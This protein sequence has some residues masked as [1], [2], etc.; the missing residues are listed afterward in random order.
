MSF[1]LSRFQRQL[2]HDLKAG[3]SGASRQ[4]LLT[5]ND[6]FVRPF[7]D[8]LN[9]RA[10][11]DPSL[12]AYSLKAMFNDQARRVGSFIS[13]QF[14][15]LPQSELAPLIDKNGYSYFLES[16]K[17]RNESFCIGFIQKLSKKIWEPGHGSY[18][19]PVIVMSNR[20]LNVIKN[21]QP[22]KLLSTL[23]KLFSY[24]SHDYLHQLTPEQGSANFVQMRTVGNSKI[25]EWGST[26]F[27]PGE[28][29][30]LS[31]ES[32]LIMSHASSFHDVCMID[33]EFK[34]EY[35]GHIDT[36]FSELKRITDE[37]AG[38]SPI[39]E[40]KQFV[41]QITNYLGIACIAS[42]ARLHKM[43]RAI[44]TDRVSALKAIDPND[45]DQESIAARKEEI[46]M[47]NPEVSELMN[48]LFCHSTEE[49]VQRLSEVEKAMVVA[50]HQETHA[51][52]RHSGPN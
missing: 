34:N 6:R 11:G 45:S 23:E 16:G 44:I 51:S 22:E 32:F 27:K 13:S 21:H 29:H 9:E 14:K 41:S 47:I 19:M 4:H 49:H 31:Y 10:P 12:P 26:Y 39:T 48:D 15:I 20:V 3:T 2:R 28:K 42:M 18:T 36:Y 37:L 5:S 1:L 46:R 7:I 43:N 52:L 33:P 38:P 17:I 35:S 40:Q 8:S 25:K 30:K 24:S 50:I